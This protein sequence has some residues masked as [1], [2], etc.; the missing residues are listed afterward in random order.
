M[1]VTLRQCIYYI[2][3]SLWSLTFFLFQIFHPKE[4]IYSAPSP[5]PQK[6]DF[7]KDVFAKVKFAKCFKNTFST[8]HFRAIASS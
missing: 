2:L 6:N 7:C 1:L 3:P 4:N 5:P 8:E